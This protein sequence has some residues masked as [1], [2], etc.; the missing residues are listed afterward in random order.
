[1]YVSQIPSKSGRTVSV[2]VRK[3]STLQ[4]YRW[5]NMSGDLNGLG[6]VYGASYDK[7]S[8]ADKSEYARLFDKY[9]KENIAM[10]GSYTVDN[11]NRGQ[12]DTALKAETENLIRASFSPRQGEYGYYQDIPNHLPVQGD[13][14]EQLWIN[15][16]ANAINYP[17]FQ[18]LTPLRALSNDI[19]YFEDKSSNF[20]TKITKKIQDVTGFNPFTLSVNFPTSTEQLKKQI[21][22]T[23]VVGAGAAAIDLVLPSAAA[24]APV[25]APVVTAVPAVVAAPA[26]VT[27][28]PAVVAPVATA[29]ASG[30][31]FNSIAAKVGTGIAANIVKASLIPKLGASGANALTDLVIGRGNTDIAD[32]LL[33]VGGSYYSVSEI[34]KLSDEI[35]R[36]Q[37][38]AYND[39]A[40]RYDSEISPQTRQTYG[41]SAT[42]EWIMPAAI[43]GALLLLMASLS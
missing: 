37:Q 9:A 22:T 36:N 21:V 30:V 14:K 27:V 28:A 31:T 20:F 2:K 39:Q 38:A 1:M 7:L 25:A 33:T 12:V 8:E 11:R 17:Q 29:V 24:T 6:D 4:G 10:G 41:A 23:A 19:G 34:N 15:Y 26:V 43:G 40:S 32:A 35:K 5:A 3:E 42:P 18:P 16:V 13:S